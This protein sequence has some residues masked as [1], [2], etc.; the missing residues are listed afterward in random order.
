MVTPVFFGNQS[1]VIPVYARAFVL[2]GVGPGVSSTNAAFIEPCVGLLVVHRV[3]RNYEFAD[4]DVQSEQVKLFRHPV[5]SGVAADD[6]LN[7]A[8]LNHGGRT[9][10]TGAAIPDATAIGEGPIAEPCDDAVHGSRVAPIG[11]KPVAKPQLNRLV[12]RPL[13][14]PAVPPR[15][16]PREQSP[17]GWGLLLAAP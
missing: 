14:A 1:A 5:V 3:F 8:D 13:R 4:R 7:R 10:T 9:H 6:D 12:P 16:R 2:A 17:I 11:I 15:D